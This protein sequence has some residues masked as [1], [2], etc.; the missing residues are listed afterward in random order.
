MASSDAAGAPTQALTAG[1]IA[2]LAALPAALVSV[3]AIALLGPPLGHALLAP[4]DVHFWSI[5]RVG[6]HP[7][8]V[9]HARFLIALTM[10]LLLSWLTVVAV[11]RSP[12]LPSGVT[13]LLVVAVQA[14][15]IG[16]AVLCVLAQEEVL[17]PLYPNAELAPLLYRYF[18]PPTLLVAAAG[19]VAL[20]ALVRSARLRAATARLCRETSARAVVAGVAA[21]AAIVVWLSHAIYTEATIGAAFRDVV[22]HVQFPLDET[23]AVLDGRSPLVDFAAQYGSLWPYAYAAAMSLLGTSVGVWIALALTT[24]GIG[25]LAIYAVLRRVAGSSIYGLLLFLPVLAASFYRVGGT[26]DERYTYGDYFG[27]FPLRFAG[28]SLLAWLV[29]RHLAGARPRRPWLL[30]LAAGLVALNNADAGLPA[31]GA[32]AAA[33][34]WT[35]GRPTRP[36]LLRFA[37]SAAGGL[38]AAFG[39][40]SALTLLRAGALPDLSLLL[41]FSRLFAAQGFA[42]VQM[43]TLGLHLVVFATFVAAIVLATVRALDA[44]PDRLLTGMLAWSGVFGL[45]AGAYFAGRSTPENL[46]AVFFPWSFALALLLVPA[47]TGIRA[48]RRRRP[49]L[50]AVACVFGFLTLACTLAQTP[51]PWRQLDRLQQRTAP[52]FATPWGQSFIAQHTRRGEPAAILVLLGH[53]IGAN[54]GVPNVSPYSAMASMP[55]SEQ[56]DETIA[57]L[58]KAGGDKL[59]LLSVTTGDDVQLALTRAG[60]VLALEDPQTDTMMWRDVRGRSRQ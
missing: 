6:V 12:R 28:P 36:G 10:P 13:D 57:D 16:F 2:W 31:L 35:G 43:P 41:R 1:E 27:M 42:M 37:L 21:T 32:T 53:R 54:L 56:L 7:E 59:F 9:E 8:P 44:D 50:A 22:Y 45:G 5:A 47:L 23:F 60:F 20:V 51:A 34:L 18:T 58:R 25:M 29:G 11:R 48:M 30:F 3:L 24:T 19:T 38:I 4:E 40:V 17:G 55:T 33:V 46:I 15:G 26:L 14:L 52:P 39:L 49:P